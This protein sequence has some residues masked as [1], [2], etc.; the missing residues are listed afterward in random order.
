MTVC[1]FDCDYM[2]LGFMEEFDWDADGTHGFDGDG[3]E[4]LVGG[5]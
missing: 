5:V 3:V 2:T 1:E 4:S